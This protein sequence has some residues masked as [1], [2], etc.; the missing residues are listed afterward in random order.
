VSVSKIIVGCDGTSRSRDA[1]R[2]GAVLARVTG[3]GLILAN[4]YQSDRDAALAIVTAAERAAP[5]GTRAEVRVIKARTP[6]HGLHELAESEGAGLC[7]VGE[8][9][10]T[11][12]QS[13]FV[14]HAPCA[15]AVGP[16]GFADD[17]D[18]GLR[19]IGVAYDGSPEARDALAVAADLALAAHGTLK[20][21]GV[22]EAPPPPTVGMTS[23]YLPGADYHGALHNELE[24]A[25]E[26]LPASLRT[27]VVMVD[28]EAAPQLIE[29]AAPLSLLVMGS[30][31]RGALGRALLGSVSERVLR[32]TPCPV[33]VVPLGTQ[34]Q[35]AAA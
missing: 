28:G 24:S 34:V 27:Q 32:A 31:G 23:L 26:E 7:V 9:H 20:L 12:G 17:P 18:P 11:R 16:A 29:Q 8:R 35:Q 14:T 25:A 22:A 4:V 2:F 10:H 1:V 33:L 13:Q 30:H 21:I 6:A 19:V 3:A 15:I 5:Y